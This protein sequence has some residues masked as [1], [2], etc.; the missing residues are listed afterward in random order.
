MF[1]ATPELIFDG[2]HDLAESPVW[3]DG[4]LWWVNITAGE[5]HRL[6]PAT[7][8]HH[9]QNIGGNTGC[10]VPC[11]DGRW[12]VARDRELLW[13][14]WKSG[15]TTL[16]CAVES[17]QPHNRFN[18]GQ[19]DPQGRL[20][21]GTM[22][23]DAVGALGALYVIEAGRAPRCVLGHIAISNGMAWSADER[24]FYFTDT[25]TNRVDVFEFDSATG[26]ISN[27]RA[28]VTFTP[29]EF[30]DGM[31]LDADGNL[32]VALWGAWS[33][34]CLDG[35]TGREL[36]RI[37]M[38]VSQ[39]SSCAFGGSQLDEL[40]IT[41]ARTGLSAAA[42]EHE[43]QAGGIFRVRPGMSGCPAR[44]FNSHAAACFQNL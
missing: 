14:D 15:G 19:C 34:V 2:R 13:L 40:F 31:T 29:E 43:P 3:R 42:L 20:W 23:K 22:N 24:V 18:D 5:L 21:V 33:V 32:W 37:R 35:W 7:G 39:P 30:P 38:P 44:S 1:E 9:Q 27:C 11:E 8:F 28:L 41:T 6:D 25:A 12:L 36:Q 16:F 10:V 26:A 17:N 4:H